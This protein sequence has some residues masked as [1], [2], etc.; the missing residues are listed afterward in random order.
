MDITV[1]KAV[2]ELLPAN[3]TDWSPYVAVAMEYLVNSGR[4]NGDP[5]LVAVNAV[6]YWVRDVEEAGQEKSGFS[7]QLQW[8]TDLFEAHRKSV[9]FLGN[10]LARAYGRRQKQGGWTSG[11]ESTVKMV[12]AAL[13]RFKQ[14]TNGDTRAAAALTLA[15]AML[16][17]RSE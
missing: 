13:D 10:G 3:I 11:H 4:Y 14:E 8:V 17:G 16:E 7:H 9:F 15:W 6:L 12:M 1:E 5:H 2:R